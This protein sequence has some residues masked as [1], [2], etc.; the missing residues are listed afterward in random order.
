M[1]RGGNLAYYHSL[2]GH[3]RR[4]YLSGL[5]QGAVKRSRNKLPVGPGWLLVEILAALIELFLEQFAEHGVNIFLIANM[6]HGKIV[7]TRL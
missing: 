7:E 2:V 6:L 1:E 4:R 5:S 3:V